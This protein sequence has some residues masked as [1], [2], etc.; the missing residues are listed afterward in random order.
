M[1]GQ[2]DAVPGRDLLTYP[3]GLIGEPGAA[4]NLLGV[5][6][7]NPADL[8]LSGDAKVRFGVGSMSTPDDVGATAQVVGAAYAWRGLTVSASVARAAVTGLVR[9]DSDPLT[10][11]ND[12]RYATVVSSIGV[13]RQRGHLAWGVA[14]RRRTG[15]LDLERRSAFGVDAGVSISGLTRRDVRLAA[16]SFLLS[17]GRAS[18]DPAS[19]F[20][21]VDMR[22]AGRDTARTARGGLAWSTTA[23]RASELFAYGAV[24]MSAWELRAGPAQSFAHGSSDV[25]LRTAIA[26]RHAGYAIGIAREELAGGLA[27]SYQLVFSAT[28]R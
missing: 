21:S 10:V 22:L 7:F 20:A 14:V 11:A 6:L 4:G 24:R 18:S 13:G 9:T 26:V 17:P 16:S 25:R 27:P 12:V 8:N 1:L 2:R 19:W 23:G 5:G 3:I 28:R 15:A